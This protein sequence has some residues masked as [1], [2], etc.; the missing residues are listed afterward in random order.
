MLTNGHIY[1]MDPKAPQAEAV[2][3]G[4]GKILATGRVCDL[5]DQFRPMRK[6]DLHGATLL[7]G[8]MDAHVHLYA[9]AQRLEWIDLDGLL[10]DEALARIAAATKKIKPG[11]WLCGGGYN[12]NLW[13][14]VPDRHMLDSVAGN[15]PV[16][17]DSKDF[18]TLWVNTALL[19]KIG[20]DANTPDPPGG[21]LDRESDGFPSGIIR[22]YASE[23]L[24]GKRPVIDIS[25][26]AE[27]IGHGIQKLYSYGLT[28]VHTPEGIEEL[29]ALQKLERENRLNFRV[30]AMLPKE[31]LPMAESLGLQAGL[32]GE[33]LNV[34]GVKLFAD[35][36][37]GSQTAYMLAPYENAGEY[38]GMAVVE[39][40]VLQDQITRAN[41]CGLAVAVHAIGDAAVRC[42]L[43]CL[44]ATQETAQRWKIRNRI[45]HLQL[46][47][48]EDLP[49]LSKLG[50]TASMQPLH[51]TSDLE[52]IKKH[53]GENRGHIYAWRSVEQSGVRLAFG[54]DAPVEVPD[55]LQ[56]I[57]A[58]ATRKRRD[59]TPAGGWHP[60]ETISVTNAIK[61]YTS[62][63]AWAAGREK[64]CGTIEPGKA[65]DFTMLDHDIIAEGPES[66]LETKVIGT[67][68]AGQWV[69]GG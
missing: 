7:P 29:G 55:P 56:G 17:L 34:I 26:R 8:L 31:A 47:S 62:G 50:V 42:V 36:S 9:Y 61:A 11:E 22:E 19:K 59:N 38:R 2:V 41:R 20:V 63:A 18:H 49:R 66:I 30:S 43:D 39:P 27:I 67:M 14:R 60:E 13:D 37:L 21:S 1:T 58:A 40:E 51:C 64:E 45:E 3:I 54:S 46:V 10:L 48:K 33:W 25:R 12:A 28:G 52:I 69:Y 5:K 24:K 6:I 23:L 4:F 65:A 44:E 57:Y 68:I 53:W 15:V 16:V 32:G 35:G